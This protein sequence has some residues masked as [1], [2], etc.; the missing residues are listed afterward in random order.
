MNDDA[1]STLQRI[2]TWMVVVL[3]IVLLV[4]GIHLHGFSAEVHHRFWNDVFGR[5]HGPMTFRFF[6]QPIMALLVAL[7]DG[8]DDARHGHSSFF[9]TNRGDPTL[10]R[11]RL[12]Q[13][14]VATARVVILGISMDVIYQLG[15]FNQFYPVEA[16]VMAILLALIPYFFFRWIVERIAVGSLPAGELRD[17]EQAR[18][19]S[20]HI[21]R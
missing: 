3:A 9:W 5:L 15:V 4:L 19:G 7:P 14:L 12:R 17:D 8:I 1:P 21:G 6:L 11:G 18:Y 13:G 20:D 16:L 2:M 10:R